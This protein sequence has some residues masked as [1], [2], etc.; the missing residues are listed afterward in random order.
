MARSVT[1]VYF[2]AMSPAIL[3]TLYWST[4]VSLIGLFY[5]IFYF[6]FNLLIIWISLSLMISYLCSQIGQMVYFLYNPNR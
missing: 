3:N 2:N 1:S 4:W 5:F 6:I